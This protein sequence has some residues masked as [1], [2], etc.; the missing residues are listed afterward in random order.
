MRVWVQPD[1]NTIKL[2]ILYNRPQ[3][4][5]LFCQR[6]CWRHCSSDYWPPKLWSI[7]GLYA[8]PPSI[9]S[10]CLVV[11]YVIVYFHSYAD[12]FIY[13]YYQ[14]Q[15]AV[16]TL[17]KNLLISEPGIIMKL[18]KTF[19][20]KCLKSDCFPNNNWQLTWLS[21]KAHSHLSYTECILW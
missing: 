6:L 9:L 14:D 15:Q 4:L 12:D 19:F 10:I 11:K 2:C 7:S 8:W 20:I 1:L 21:S 17:K 5:N 18:V 16:C 3:H 13:L